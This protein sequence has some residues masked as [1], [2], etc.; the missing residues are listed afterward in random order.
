MFFLPSSTCNFPTMI[1][2]FA[3]LTKKFNFKVEFIRFTRYMKQSVRK[4]K[5]KY[6]RTGGTL[7]RKR[8]LE[9]DTSCELLCL[10]LEH[11]T[12]PDVTLGKIR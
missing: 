10:A 6:A 8:S 2:F 7:T 1:F 5:K 9:Y 3:K 11:G 12:C 4:V